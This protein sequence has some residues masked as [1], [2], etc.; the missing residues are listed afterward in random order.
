MTPCQLQTSCHF[1]TPLPSPHHF[2]VVCSKHEPCPFQYTFKLTFVSWQLIWFYPI[3][4]RLR[5]P[6]RSQLV[7]LYCT[8]HLLCRSFIP[9]IHANFW[10]FRDKPVMVLGTILLWSHTFMLMSIHIHRKC[11]CVHVM[12]ER[13]VSLF[14]RYFYINIP[15]GCWACMRASNFFNRTVMSLV[16]NCLCEIETDIY[17]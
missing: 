6:E 2:G 5:Y 7:M 8:W 15:C 11:S 17:G 14:H 13:Y 12:Y 10:T 4:V 9:G 1:V 3:L 16:W